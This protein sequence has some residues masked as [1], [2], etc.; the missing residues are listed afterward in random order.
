MKIMLQTRNYNKENKYLWQ[1]YKLISTV[2]KF[3]S[4]PREITQT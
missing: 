2:T 1:R 3:P 4:P